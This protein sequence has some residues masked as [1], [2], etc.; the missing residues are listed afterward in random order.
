MNSFRLRA[1]EILIAA[2]LRR[3]G[4]FEVYEA[5]TA[6]TAEGRAALSTQSAAAFAAFVEE[7][8]AAYDRPTT[9]R[10]GAIFGNARGTTATYAPTA[11]GVD[12]T[13]CRQCGAARE[14][15]ACAECQYCGTPFFNSEPRP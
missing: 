9:R 8:L 5:L 2:K 11:A 14:G 7:Q 1:Q 10:L 12:T 15:V 4:T 3:A 13:R 6:L